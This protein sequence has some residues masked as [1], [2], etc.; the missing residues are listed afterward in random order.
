MANIYT[1][2]RG[3]A[4]LNGTTAIRFTSESID[5]PLA[6]NVREDIHAGM[7]SDSVY[8]YDLVKPTGDIVFPLTSDNT[9]GFTTTISSD[10]ITLISQVVADPPKMLAGGGDLKIYRGDVIKTLTSPWINSIKISG[11]AGNP[12]EVTVNLMS[13]YG[14]Y[15]EQTLSDPPNVT[16]PKARAIM[17]NEL[18]F[19]TTV[20]RLKL[21]TLNN[22]VIT[23]RSFSVLIETGLVPDDSYNSTNPRA[24]RGFALGRLS[25]SGDLEFVGAAINST[26]IAPPRGTSA[27][28]GN[29]I[30]W[31]A[32]VNI[33]DLFTIRGGL[34]NSRSMQT[35]GMSEIAKTSVTFKALYSLADA[36]GD[37]TKL[38]VAL[39]TLLGGTGV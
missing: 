23:P 24:L 19:A 31:D 2:W 10:L 22:D 5:V 6:I 13:I 32:S 33:G 28:E 37:T 30:P 20:S 38:P 39:G 26:N 8:E 18:D 3:L 21:A 15:S 9:T 25:V 29:F 1:G 17:F 16:L 27:G 36:G 12:V 35:P 14:E 11:S 4:V 34:W 7:R